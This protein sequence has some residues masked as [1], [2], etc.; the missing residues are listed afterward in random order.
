MGHGSIGRWKSWITICMVHEQGSVLPCSV[1]LQFREKPGEFF[2]YTALS[3]IRMNGA[4]MTSVV[5]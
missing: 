1:P 3:D 4:P 2:L 5:R